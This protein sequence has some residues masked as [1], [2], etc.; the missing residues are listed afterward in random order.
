MLIMKLSI[1]SFSLI[2][3]VLGFQHF[4]CKWKDPFNQHQNGRVFLLVHVHSLLR[5]IVVTAGMSA[6]NG[7]NFKNGCFISSLRTVKFQ[8]VREGYQTAFFNVLA[9]CANAQLVLV[10]VCGKSSYGQ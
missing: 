7:K 8:Y 10:A 4:F 5:Y 6:N 9:N 1:C 2:A 3:Q